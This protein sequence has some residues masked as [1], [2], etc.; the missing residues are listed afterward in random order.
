[1]EEEEQEY[2]RSVDCWGVGDV[3][4]KMVFCSNIEM[5]QVLFNSISTNA[6]AYETR[7]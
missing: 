7:T 4:Y 1:M 3:M 6:L 2:N 5:K